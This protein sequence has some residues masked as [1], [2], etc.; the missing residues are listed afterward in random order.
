MD[1][2]IKSGNDE[3]ARQNFVR[4]NYRRAVSCTI[5]IMRSMTSSRFVPAGKSI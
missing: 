2:R 5:A 4:F 1:C 3:K